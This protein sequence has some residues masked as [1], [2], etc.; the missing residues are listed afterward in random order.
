MCEFPSQKKSPQSPKT[1]SISFQIYPNVE[2][3]MKNANYQ[4]ESDEEFNVWEEFENEPPVPVKGNQGGRNEKSRKMSSNQKSSLQKPTEASLRRQ[5]EVKKE[6]PVKKVCKE[7]RDPDAEIQEI[8]EK[9]TSFQKKTCESLDGLRW[10]YRKLFIKVFKNFLN[11]CR[12]TIM[13]EPELE[14]EEDYR[15]RQ[16][17]STEFTNRFAR[18]YLY[19]IGR[20]VSVQKPPQSPKN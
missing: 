6:S 7:K 10:V 1:N 5:K 20:V 13:V 19:Q 9:I 3:R 15:R 11:Y 4:A 8:F 2:V 12:E 14:D 18:N 17:R 16:Q